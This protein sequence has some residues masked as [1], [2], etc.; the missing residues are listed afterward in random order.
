MSVQTATLNMLQAVNAIVTKA[1]SLHDGI[2]ETVVVLGA[3]GATR[4][5]QK[6]GHYAPQSWGTRK[7]AQ[8]NGA[9]SQAGDD[10]PREVYGEILLA[11]ESLGRGA[12]ATL[13]TILHELVHAYCDAN[14]IKDTSNGHRY[15]NTKFK[16]KAEEF[17][18]EIEKADTIGWSV[19][20]VPETTVSVYQEEID[21]LE[22][23]INVNRLG[24]LE[25]AALGVKE[26]DEEKKQPLKR[27]IQ[28]PECQEPLLVT[29]KWWELQGNGGGD[30]ASGMGLLC[31]THDAEYEIFE[32][33]GD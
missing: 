23:A 10:D 17:G 6:H 21:R 14:K 29:K 3:S 24:Y 12:V 16:E 11:G 20:S 33:G 5:G 18:L 7:T 8:A 32:E 28:C 13:G 30:Y 2:P 4:S 27:K 22:A 1:R 31:A 26:P 19:T 15:H 25:L 9:D